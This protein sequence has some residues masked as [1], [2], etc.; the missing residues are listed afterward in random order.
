MQLFEQGLQLGLKQLGLQLLLP[1]AFAKRSP[2]PHN[3]KVPGFSRLSSLFS[4]GKF[5]LE[6]PSPINCDALYLFAIGGTRK[7]KTFQLKSFQINLLLT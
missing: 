7:I 3:P 4:F 5:S 1:S 6:T 2:T